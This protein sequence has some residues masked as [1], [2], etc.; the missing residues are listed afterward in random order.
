MTGRWQ[1]KTLSIPFEQRGELD[2]LLNSYGQAGW[3]LV[4]LVVDEWRSRGLTGGARQATY[5]AVFKA[6]A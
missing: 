1:Y 5:R 6:P 2:T 3:E 4:S